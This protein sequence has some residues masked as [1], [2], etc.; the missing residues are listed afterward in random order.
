MKTLKLENGRWNEIVPFE[1][2]LTPLKTALTKTR[3]CL[4]EMEKQGPL[5]CKYIIEDNKELQ[6]LTKS[7]IEKDHVVQWL[8][9]DELKQDQFRF[10]YECI[11]I[12][13]DSALKPK[14]LSLDK[15]VLES[16]IPKLVA[17][18]SLMAMRAIQNK[19][20][21]E[22]KKVKEKKAKN[23]AILK[24][25]PKS[26]SPLKK[27]PTS[28]SKSPG[29]SKSPSKSPEKGKSPGK[30]KGKKE[31]VEEEVVEEKD[32]LEMTEDEIYF[33]RMSEGENVN[34]S[35]M[36]EDQKAQFLE[37]MERKRFGRYWIW[38]GYF[39][40]KHEQQ[41][42]DTTESLKHINQ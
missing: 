39:N 10:L 4:L 30:K 33:K 28:K 1:F 20:A 27:A 2:Y 38:E 23:E 34:L 36:S 17:F 21:E 18:K 41:W 16:V 19:K 15:T 22:M 29:K 14:L 3:N 32:P 5:H 12:I 37:D 24:S 40:Q 42:L 8:V 25:K 31:E 13:Y 9:G 35:Y 7:L 6:D 11:K 26:T